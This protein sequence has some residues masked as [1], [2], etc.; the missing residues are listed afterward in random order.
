MKQKSFRLL[1][2]IM[3][4]GMVLT[5]CNI[6]EAKGE[7]E[8]KW[9]EYL[10]MDS[11]YPIIKDEYADDI[12]LKMIIV[13]DST[14]SE[15]NDLYVA[16]YLKEKYNLTFEVESI[17]STAVD[18]RKYLLF[19]SGELPDI[20]LNM[21]L[22]TADI[23]NYGQEEGMLLKMDEYISEE[24]T[25]GIYYYLYGEGGR[26]DA[27]SAATTPDGHIYVL[28]RLLESNNMALYAST[29]INRKMVEA[30]GKEMPK[31]LDEFTDVMYAIKN[32][33]L[34]GI[35]SENVYPLGTGMKN[36]NK[37]TAWMILNAFG[38]VTRNAYGYS[39]AVRNGKFVIP[40]YDMEVF[41]EYLKVMNQYFTDGIINPNY[42]T[43]EE[44]EE[45]AQLLNGISAVFPT[46]V[47]IQG[48][49]TW[50]EWDACYPLTSQWNDTPVAHKDGAVAVNRLAISAHTKYPELCMRVMDIFY[51][52]QTDDPM[53]FSDGPLGGCPAYGDDKNLGF[54][55]LYVYDPE[56]GMETE[57]P[58]L[59][60][61]YGHKVNNL[62]GMYPGF[63]TFSLEDCLAA[64]YREAGV[65]Y[66]PYVF[67]KTKNGDDY[68]KVSVSE[69][70]APNQAKYSF[71]GIYFVDSQTNQRLTDLAT[72]IEPYIKEQ[73]ALF[74]TGNRPISETE[75][76][77]K[78][79]Q[80]M[81]IED[82]MAIYQQIYDNYLAT[83]GE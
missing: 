66:H 42:F 76:F 57:N 34:P 59:N 39:P 11:V 6:P 73:V 63:G 30:V 56:T 53:L 82:L 14:A 15:W 61:A 1:A 51:N 47:Y 71:P 83:L 60:D 67:D 69:N 40:A 35:G 68:Y 24:L 77:V 52:T 17:P 7:S 36:S 29:F 18:D 9:P 70:V 50:N 44:T 75:A 46:P 32:A 79:L 72:V 81:G 64:W 20:I 12:T 43:M 55:P 2:L 3:A 48:V 37:S 31:T 65:E 74:I 13:Q 41:Q 33:D 22:S 28:P 62:V 10:N 25:P 5:V 23:L 54:E 21:V 80:A 45:K 49:E 38:Y 27:R 58:K 78:E 19:N 26:S 16:K 4:I 8:S